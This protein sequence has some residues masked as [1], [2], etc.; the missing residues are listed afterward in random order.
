MEG[1]PGMSVTFTPLPGLLLRAKT[2]DA[3]ADP[4]HVELVDEDSFCGR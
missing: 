1:K 4:I 2:P 3:M